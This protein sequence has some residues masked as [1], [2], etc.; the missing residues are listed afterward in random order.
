[1]GEVLRNR[2]PNR[3]VDRC[4]DARR[5]ALK[6]SAETAR[7]GRETEEQMSRSLMVIVMAVWLFEAAAIY[8]AGPRPWRFSL[9]VLFLGVTLLS[10]MFAALAMISRK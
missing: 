4:A 9:K 10:L 1:M 5:R 3:S 6:W 8:F 2:R 7:G